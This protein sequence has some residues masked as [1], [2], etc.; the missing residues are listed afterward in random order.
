MIKSDITIRIKGP[1]SI[2][3]SKN[4]QNFP[5]LPNKNEGPLHFSFLSNSNVHKLFKFL[6]KLYFPAIF[7][8]PHSNINLLFSISMI[9]YSFYVL[10]LIFYPITSSILFSSF[11]FITHLSYIYF[12]YIQNLTSHKYMQFY[13]RKTNKW[14]SFLSLYVYIGIF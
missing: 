10:F 7:K 2:Y 12:P 13:L 8:Q 1:R 4:I 9:Y 11:S 3:H 14:T 6:F 5:F